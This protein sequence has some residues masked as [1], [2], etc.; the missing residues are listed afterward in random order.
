MMI[1]ASFL[2]DLSPSFQVNFLLLFSFDFV[3][4]V[5]VSVCCLLAEIE[6]ELLT[7][8]SD[9]WAWLCHCPLPSWLK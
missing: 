2:D 7:F 9:R 6:R 4:C 5:C 3:Q 1:F 8:A